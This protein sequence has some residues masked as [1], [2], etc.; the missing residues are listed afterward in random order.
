MAIHPPRASAFAKRL[1]IWFPT[2]QYYYRLRDWL[3]AIDL[4]LPAWLV[5]AFTLAHLRPG[6]WPRMLVP[7]WAHQYEGQFDRGK[8]YLIGWLAMATL[9]VFTF[10]SAISA[11]C[12]GLMLAAHAGAMIDLAWRSRTL[13]DQRTLVASVV[14]WTAA[15]S[16]V[17]LALYT[18]LRMAIFT[19]IDARQWMIDEP[20]FAVG[21]VVLFRPL[22]S[23]RSLPR[24]G[25]VVVYTRQGYSIQ[26]EYHRIL[27]RPAG[28][29][30]DRVIAGPESIVRWR[31]GELTV[32]GKPA[33]LQA[34]NAD[35]M[36][37]DFELKVP[38]GYVCI[39]PSTDTLLSTSGSLE[40]WT[41]QSLVPQDAILGRAVVRNYP[42]WRFWWIQ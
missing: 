22:A 38:S 32:N 20:P 40:Q 10:G 24:P 5:D 13:D 11:L 25:E 3:G 19:A 34:I 14:V 9:C 16:V 26:R 29:G 18:P 37:G 6:T 4:S 7:G 21:D 15:A 2:L 17:V 39:F 31:H 42:F 41:Q 23:L 36:P 30:M 27:Q 33:E 35:R 1:R 12:A 8:W 28:Q